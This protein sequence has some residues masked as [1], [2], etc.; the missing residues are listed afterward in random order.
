MMSVS[1]NTI[2]RIP[3]LG[4]EGDIGIY[5]IVVLSFFQVVIR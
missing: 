1:V 3:I 2:Q 5:G 4:F